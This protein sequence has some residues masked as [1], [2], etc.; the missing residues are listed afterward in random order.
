M[1]TNSNSSNIAYFAIRVVVVAFVCAFTAVSLKEKQAN[2]VELD[3]KIQ[4][5]ASINVKANMSDAEVL[6]DKYVKSVVVTNYKGELLEGFEGFKIDL[7]KENQKSEEE[8][9]LPV[10]IC[11]KDGQTYYVFSL[12][13]AGLWGPDRKSVV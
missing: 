7:Q 6:Y 13:G 3:K 5:L 12:R 1:N 9:Q 11:Q 10:F 4:I 2:H 8:R